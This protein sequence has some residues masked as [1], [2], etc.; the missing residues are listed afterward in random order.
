MLHMREQA[1]GYIRVS[2]KG[3]LDGDGFPRQ[4]Q[5]I[6]Q[7][8]KANGMEVVETFREEGV[9]GKTELEHRPALQA[10]LE[11]L[12]SGIVKTVLIEKLDRLARDLMVQETILSD[13]QKNGYE[14]VSVAEPDLCNNDP[15]RKLVRQIFGAIAEYDR[16]MTVLKLK[17]A[18]QRMRAKS[19]RCEGE[20]PFGMLPGESDTITRMRALRVHGLSYQKIAAALDDAGVKPRYGK[21]W[22]PIVI[23]RVLRNQSGSRVTLARGELFLA[24][25]P[26]QRSYPGSVDIAD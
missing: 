7:Y 16:A 11:A 2:G 26:H 20:R 13:M 5:A 12:R 14:L 6:Q 8:A 24:D 21:R 4:I 25:F 10:L 3:Q 19:G 1:F 22:N 15:S 23:N 18:R 9:S 17:A